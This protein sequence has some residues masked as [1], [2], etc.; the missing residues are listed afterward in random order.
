VRTH[1][2]LTHIELRHC[3]DR[4]LAQRFDVAAV[5]LAE[6]EALIVL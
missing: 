4:A 2:H 5:Y 1:L 6:L 3:I